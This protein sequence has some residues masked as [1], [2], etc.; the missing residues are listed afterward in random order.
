MILLPIEHAG[1]EG[2]KS[3]SDRTDLAFLSKYQSFLCLLSFFLC[4]TCNSSWSKTILFVQLIQLLNCS[5]RTMLLKL[6][7]T[8]LQHI[9]S[10]VT[11][12]LCCDLS[13]DVG[14]Q[15][16]ITIA[17]WGFYSLI[18]VSRNNSG[19]LRE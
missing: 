5:I 3:I 13:I 1:M 15:L 17:S 18:S 14:N 19:V 2:S 10:Y 11:C 16:A 12:S 7:Q 9:L 4:K 6:F 8:F